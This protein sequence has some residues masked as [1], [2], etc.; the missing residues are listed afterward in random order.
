MEDVLRIRGVYLSRRCLL[1]RLL[2]R[3]FRFAGEGVRSVETDV[4]GIYKK[5]GG[6]SKADSPPIWVG[7]GIFLHEE[8]EQYTGCYGRSDDTGYVRPHGV[9]EEIVVRIVFAAYIVRDA[10]GHGYGGNAGVTDERVEFLV[11]GQD[12]VEDFHEEHSGE[13]GDTEGHESEEE[14]LQSGR[15]DEGAGLR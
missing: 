8:S 4:R 15:G 1:L 9:H 5:T 12:Q 6:P 7:M 11:F 14:D 13:S 10:C 2:R 3:F